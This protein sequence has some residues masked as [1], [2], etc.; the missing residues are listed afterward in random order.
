MH[1]STL[2]SI[3]ALLASA[4]P[5][6][7]AHAAIVGARGMNGSQ[8]RAIGVLATTPRDGTRRNPFQQDASIIRD[9]EIQSGEVGPC[10]RTLA[11]GNNNMQAG[12]QEIM[13][14]FG[15]LPLVAPGSTLT[16]TVHQ[17]NADGAG[18][19]TCEVSMDGTGA[20][21]TGV[22]IQQNLPGRNGRN[23][24]TN[25]TPQ[26]LVVTMPAN[27]QCTGGANGDMCMVRCRNP[28]RAGP[29]GGC[30]PVQ[31]APNGAGAGNGNG[32]G[33]G[34]GGNGNAAG[35]ANRNAGGANRNAGGANRNA[36]GA[37]GNGGAAGGNNNPGAG[38]GEE[39]EA[40]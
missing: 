15:E 27:L 28:A 23:R 20:Q 26:D 6:A 2:L 35:G 3:A 32:N 31:Q 16:M 11:G 9:R 25:T 30:I 17:V 36:G 34:A 24:A 12:V 7:N 40:A 5:L 1:F 38:A 21:F 13:S 14:E 33:A 22:Q 39:E 4:V 8:G 18:P 10:G 29:F 19:Y 37:N